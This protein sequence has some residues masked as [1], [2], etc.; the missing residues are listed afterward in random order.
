V[1]IA[2]EHWPGVV[3]MAVGDA[4]ARPFLRAH[5][6]LVTPVECGDTG[7]PDDLDTR[8]DFDRLASLV[9]PRG[10]SGDHA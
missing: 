5:P 3:A 2:R 10:E 4:G 7:R 8:S 6:E 1:L 9:P